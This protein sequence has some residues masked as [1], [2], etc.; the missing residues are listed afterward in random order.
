MS[1]IDEL[2]KLLSNHEKRIITLE[3]LLPSKS[4]TVSM[5]GESVILSLIQNRF[6]DQPKKYGDVIKELKTQAKHNSKHNY[7]KILKKLT[8]EDHLERKSSHKHLAF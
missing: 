4:P 8:S 2:K 3:K 6:F 7:T 5:D 1:E